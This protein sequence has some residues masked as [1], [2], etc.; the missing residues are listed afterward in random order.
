MDRAGDTIAEQMAKFEQRSDEIRNR[1]RSLVPVFF[2]TS[3]WDET[4]YQAWSAIVYAIIPDIEMLE[5]MLESFCEI[6]GN[7]NHDACMQHWTHGWVF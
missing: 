7:A 2:A 3:I 5:K 4:L 1:S 6:A